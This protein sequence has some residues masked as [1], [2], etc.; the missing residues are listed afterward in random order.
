MPCYGIVNGRCTCGGTHLEPKDV[1]KHPSIAEWNANATNDLGTV[2]SWWPADGQSNV[3]VFCRP[4]GF[5]V[6]DIDPR[7]GGP[8][9]FEKFEELVEGALPPTVEA[10]TGEYS[11]GGRSIRGRHIFYK[12][13]EAEA[14]VGNLKKSGLNGIDI[15][16]N[17]YVL[18]SPSRHFSGV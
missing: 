8:E 4:S 6:I 10:I 13:D 3:S 7:S 12:C 18:I 9:S 14:L 2:Q 11:A 5:F 17:G 16:H 15:K 1:G